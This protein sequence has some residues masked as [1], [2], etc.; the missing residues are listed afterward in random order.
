MQT[1]RNTKGTG[2]ERLFFKN[3]DETA[4]R[5]NYGRVQSEPSFTTGTASHDFWAGPSTAFYFI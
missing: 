5:G 2:N 3:I 4:A 1:G